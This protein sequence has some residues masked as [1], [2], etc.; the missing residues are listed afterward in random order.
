MVLEKRLPNYKKGGRE[1]RRRRF[2]CTICDY[3]KTIFASGDA[4]EKY[5]PERGI[6]QAEAIAKRESKNREF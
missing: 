1:Y 5:I 2:K 3:Q 4:D 6:Q